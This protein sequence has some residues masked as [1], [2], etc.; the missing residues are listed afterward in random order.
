MKCA[1]KV[2]IAQKVP[3]NFHYPSFSSLIIIQI[4]CY[5]ISNHLITIEIICK[6]ICKNRI[7]LVIFSDNAP[8]TFDIRNVIKWCLNDNQ[9][10]KIEAGRFH[11]IFCTVTISC[12][13][14]VLYKSNA[15]QLHLWSQNDTWCERL[16]SRGGA[17]G[18]GNFLENSA[19]LPLFAVQRFSTY[20]TFSHSVSGVKMTLNTSDYRL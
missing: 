16:L 19:Q 1:Q 13:A 11:G 12:D 14:V 17:L 10:E 9:A 4:S 5:C 8:F 7:F 2:A 6:N 3:G 15:W 20:Q 18:T